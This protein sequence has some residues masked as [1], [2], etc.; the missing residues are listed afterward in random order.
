M[1]EVAI[2]ASLRAETLAITLDS[3]A[4][5]VEVREP[6]RFHINLDPAGDGAAEDVVRVCEDRDL[7]VRWN[8]PDRA[9]LN[10]ALRWCY[11]APESAAFFF[12]EDDVEFIRPFA[13]S[14]ALDEFAQH[15]RLAYLAVPRCPFP[16][17]DPAGLQNGPEQG[18]VTWRSGKYKMCLGPGLLLRGYARGV[19]DR[20][21]DFPD[22]ELQFHMMTSNRDLTE[23][24][25][26]WRFATFG[27]MSESWSVQDIGKPYRVDRGLVWRDTPEGTVWVKA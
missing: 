26:Q 9:N 24:T 1:I 21:A 2:T 13:L 8:L 19:A 14:D 17:D 16:A 3:F 20:M 6:V 23:Y 12:M 25:N 5:F 4:R 15:E 7:D 10:A 27:T 22:P 18:R 11:R